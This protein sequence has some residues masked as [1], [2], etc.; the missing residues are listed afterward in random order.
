MSYMFV[1][2]PCIVC[3]NPF[4][5]NPELV[6][7]VRVNAHGKPDPNGKRE[8]ICRDCVERGNEVRKERGMPPI[9]ILPGAYEAQEVP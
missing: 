4:S 9:E 6:P 8:G 2:A 3:G 5:F 1:M 7:S